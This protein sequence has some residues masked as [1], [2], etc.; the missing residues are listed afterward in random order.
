MGVAMIPAGDDHFYSLMGYYV[1]KGSAAINY[2]IIIIIT[3]R[4]FPTKVKARAISFCF[5][6]SR[7]GGLV[8]PYVMH[9]L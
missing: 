8:M 5:F 2:M 9:H 4:Y 3:V 6:M 1:S 7:L